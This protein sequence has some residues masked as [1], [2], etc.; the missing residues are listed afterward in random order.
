MDSREAGPVTAVTTSEV[1]DGPGLEALHAQLM[2][3][4]EDM[5]HLM[6]QQHRLQKHHQMVLQ[7]IGREIPTNDLLP[8]LLY[9][10]SPWAMTTDAYGRI[11]HVNQ[12]VTDQLER[13]T[14]SLRGRSL[15]DNVVP[16]QQL[17][18]EAVLK[19]FTSQTAHSGA[20][21]LTLELQAFDG[22]AA[23]RCE[24]LVMQASNGILSDIYWCLREYDPALSREI[25]VQ[26]AF[27]AAVSSDHGLMITDP[28]GTICLVNQ[29][30][31]TMS[32]FSEAELL[33][34]NPRMMSSGR[35]D[36]HFYQDFWLEL[37][38]H[39]SWSGTIFNRRKGG[40]IF[41]E[42][43]AIKLVESPD[44]RVISYISAT[45]DLT[46][47]DSAPSQL[48][49]MAYQD[50]L[51]GLANRR[52]LVET[53]NNALLVASKGKEDLSVLFIDLDRFKPV[54]DE[55]G[56]DVGD[57][58]LKEVAERIRAALLPGDFLARV[59][60]DEFVVL[61]RTSARAHMAESVARD[62][63]ARVRA[64]LQAGV[65]SVV[66]GASI[67]CARYPQDGDDMITLLTRADD[68]MYAAKRF[69][70][71][72]SYFDAGQNRR[73]EPNLEFEIWHALERNEL[74]L[75]Y[76][77]QVRSGS[78]TRLRGCEVLV[79]WDHPTRGAIGTPTFIPIAEKNG[80][81]V[82]IGK[83]VITQACRQLQ[84][85][86][87]HGLTDFVMSV[88][89]S[90]RQL[91]DP[92]FAAFV[93][94]VLQ[95][96][97]VPANSLE[98][99]FSETDTQLFRS[100]DQ[101][102]IKALRDLG[103]GVAIDDFGISFSSLSRLSSLSISG[104]KINSQFVQ[105]LSKSDDAKAISRCL[106]AIGEA[107]NIEVIAQ[108]VESADQALLLSSQGC[109]VIQGFYAGQ[110]MSPDDLLAMALRD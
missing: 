19:K 30:L 48:R 26:A 9:E 69:N 53:F 106:V 21:Q 49:Q 35:H 37:L 28:Y 82:G 104:L 100:E 107:L 6:Q 102:H 86:S 65:H 17:Q 62:I 87:R 76:Q 7:S 23:V 110:P 85:W 22:G 18:L 88:N 1:S 54:N 13:R 67:G 52:S 24:A 98:L 99:E 63:N 51:T 25:D 89:V 93:Q 20:V 94:K 5:E 59:G 31:I 3:Y 105:D 56:H 72:F 32:G 16:S 78:L 50:P 81:I 70:L 4:A 10:S 108:G 96:T 84:Q 92:G 66:V 101:R 27:V 60:G 40:Q 41:L 39:G 57:L 12:L 77:P 103:V 15:L 47:T 71:Q 73:A 83:W 55:L 80:A 74:R 36:K 42:W 61:L 44:G 29:P 91:R 90:L 97:G 95:D 8:T 79:R 45:V 38:D 75:L 2:R 58:V 46:Q 11:L 14:G 34:N 109:R 64:P 33:G 68:A 43:Q